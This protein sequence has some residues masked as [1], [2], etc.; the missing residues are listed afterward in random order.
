MLASRLPMQAY[1]RPTRLADALAT[2]ADCNPSILAGGTDFYPARLV[3]RPS[4][5]VLDI[6]AIAALR[7]IVERRNHWRM[8]ATT[9]WTDILEA[10]LPGYFDALKL[11][12]R[13]IGGVQVQNT[14]TLA[15]NLC[16]ASPAADGVPALLVM[17]AEV[18][19]T[20]VGG[21][22]T[23][24]VGKFIVGPRKTA[25]LPGELVTA[26]L[27]PKPAGPARSSFLKL[28]ARKYLLISIAMVAAAIELDR[29]VVRAARV[30][31]GACS[32]QARRLPELE[33]GLIGLEP[34][35]LAD[36]V[37]AAHLGVLSPISDVRADQGYRGDAAL[38]LVRRTLR[39]LA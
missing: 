36:A 32:P 15:G 2:L 1:A 37:R 5:R 27:V 7:G 38:E 21:T 30:A 13:E 33:A 23:L 17:D 28:G 16:N 39:A 3:P 4:E 20:R 25:L 34:H 8:G 26:I 14:G 6:T 18:E 12:A 19:L 31:V 22:R 10:G 35:A 24:P 11:C 29:K 9:T